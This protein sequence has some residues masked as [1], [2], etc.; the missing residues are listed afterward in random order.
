M[1]TVYPPDGPFVTALTSIASAWNS[2]DLLLEEVHTYLNGDDE[3]KEAFAAVIAKGVQEM[4]EKQARI[5]VNIEA[6]QRRKA[7]KEQV[8]AAQREENR[9]IKA[10]KHQARIEASRLAKAKAKACE[11]DSAEAH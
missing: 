5:Q 6:S 7:E 2:K 10:G 8:R 1:V 3:N 11:E 9:R 4:V